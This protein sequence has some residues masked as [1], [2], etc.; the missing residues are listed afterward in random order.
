M[1]LIV[2]SVIACVAAGC[3]LAYKTPDARVTLHS[4]HSAFRGELE[5]EMNA[6][7]VDP[8]HEAH[9]AHPAHPTRHA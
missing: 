4:K 9:P 7:H 2:A 3:V 6:S 8:S 5:A 1:G